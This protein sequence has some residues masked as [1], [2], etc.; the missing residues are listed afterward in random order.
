ML[1]DSNI[2]IDGGQ[3]GYDN[4]RRFIAVNAP[5]VS[6]VSYVET[7]GDHKLRVEE[8][9]YLE[10]FFAVADMLPISDSILQEAVRLR[11][12]RRISLAD[13]LIAATA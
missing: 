8:R 11:Q 3:P 1:I 13:A 4:V 5:Y 7:L 6:V 9:D 12:Q 2:I 10:E